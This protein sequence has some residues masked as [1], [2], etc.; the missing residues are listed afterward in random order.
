VSRKKRTLGEGALRRQEWLPRG[1]ATR[2]RRWALEEQLLGP[3]TAA[4]GGETARELADELAHEHAGLARLEEDLRD[5]LIRI[6]RLERRLADLDG[7]DQAGVAGHGQPQ[8]S[9]ER[10]AAPRRVIRAHSSP[11][12]PGEEYWLCRCEGF[13]VDAPDGRV[14]V[15]EGLRFLSRLDRPDALEV[16]GGRF[17]RDLTLI[18]TDLVDRVDAADRRLVLRRPM[19][20]RGDRLQGLLLH[21]RPAQRAAGG[22][23]SS[24]A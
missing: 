15:V 21:L 12:R 4:G 16:R 11:G 13:E 10:P 24:R 7:R 14:G 22:S 5:R 6:A 9:A 18:P 2:R 1:R 8:P 17:G 23:G 20:P 19:R 3:S